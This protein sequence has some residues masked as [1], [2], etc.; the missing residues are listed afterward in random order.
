MLTQQEWETAV[1]TRDISTLWGECV[2]RHAR[3]WEGY[4]EEPEPAPKD[5]KER[6]YREARFAKLR[7]RPFRYRLAFR[8]AARAIAEAADIPLREIGAAR[9]DAMM[10]RRMIMLALRDGPWQMTQE[11]IVVAGDGTRG[12]SWGQVVHGLIEARALAEVNPRLSLMAEAG[13]EAQTGS[14]YG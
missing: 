8:Q 14:V 9:N 11:Q 4:T 2:E 1:A 10:A 12:F 5:T 3:Y 7:E 13:K 6:N